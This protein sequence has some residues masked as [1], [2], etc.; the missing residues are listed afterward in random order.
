MKLTTDKNTWE[1]QAQSGELNFHIQ[2]QFRPSGGLDRETDHL[3]R[4]FGFSP[5]DYKNKVII[6]AGCGSML[7]TKFFKKAFIIGIDPLI[8]EYLKIRW[9]D[10]NLASRLYSL[11]LEEEIPELEEIADLVISINVLDHCYDFQKCVENL[12]FYTKDSGLCFLSFDSHEQGMDSMH[13][14]DLNDN[15]CRQIFSKVGFKL[16]KFEKGRVYGGGD[17][18]LNYWLKI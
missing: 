7:R 1:L 16:D 17:F 12:Y 8:D 9:S 10:L 11:P 4:T 6:D 5:K 18:S 13:P 15:M 3:F 2:D 14:L